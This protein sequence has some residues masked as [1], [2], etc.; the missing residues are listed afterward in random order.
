VTSSS[1]LV[2]DNIVEAI[3]GANVASYDADGFPTGDV[4]SIR[5][6]VPPYM[7]AGAG[8]EVMARMPALEVCQLPTAGFD[9]VRA[10]LPAGVTL[11][12]AAGVHDASTAEL[13][14]GLILA[15]LRGIDGFARAMPAGEWRHDARPALADRRVL[16]VGAGG[17]GRA[18]ARR[19]HG[20]ECDVLLVGRTARDTVRGADELDG[21]LPTADVVVLAVPLDESTRGL[22]DAAFLARMRDGALL[23]NVSRGQV[24]VTEALAAEVASGRLQ[25]ALDVVDPEPLPVD[26]ALWRTPGVLISPHVGGNSTAFLPRIRRLVAEQVERWRR[27][28]HLANVVS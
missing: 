10:Y 1:V 6:Y 25:A 8:F 27:G 28:E 21:L 22:V 7:G 4:S 19:L 16:V 18:L 15:S 26:H 14:V 9:H 23:V 13:A 12:N 20:F 3:A 5:F 24:V 17:I 2:P 11:C